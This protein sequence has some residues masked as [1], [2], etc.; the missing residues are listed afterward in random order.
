MLLVPRSWKTLRKSGWFF[1]NSVIGSRTQFTSF[2]KSLVSGVLVDQDRGK[3]YKTQVDQLITL[4]VSAVG[5]FSVRRCNVHRV[6]CY[7]S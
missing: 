1:V 6:W 3:K 4:S 7:H 5:N 2:S